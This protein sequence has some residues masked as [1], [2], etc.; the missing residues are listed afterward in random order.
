MNEIISDY[1]RMA[2]AEVGGKFHV[3]ALLRGRGIPVPDFFCLSRRLHDRWWQPARAEAAALLA[4]VDPRDRA[5]VTDAA[6]RLQALV[7]TLDIDAATCRAVH[8]ALDRHLGNAEYV[9]VRACMLGA[10]PEWSEDSV[11]DPHAGISATALYV[12]R[13]DVIARVRDGW[14]SAYSEQALLYRL[15]QGQDALGVSVAIGVQRM[16]FGERSFVMFTCD[17]NTT[18]RDTLLIAGHGIG[19]GVVQEAV[20]V[21]HYFVNAKS[22]AIERRLAVKHV[23]LGFDAERGQGLREFEVAPER[24]EAACL[25]DDEIRTLQALGRKIEQVFGWP[26]DIEGTLDAQGRVHILQARP[27]SID[28]VRKRLWTGLNI[29]E[30]YP[31]VSSPLTYSL[32]RLFYRVIFRDIYR[33]AGAPDRQL[34]EHHH[35]LDRMIG[36]VNGRIYYSLNAF[37]LLHGLVP[38][39]PWLCKAWENMVGLKTSYFIDAGEAAPVLPAWRRGW[40]QLRGWS[41]FAREFLML[42]RR[43][44]A[45]KQWWRERALQSRRVLQDERDALA[46][47]EEFHRLWRDVGR[48]WGV[49]LIND[50]Y[51]FT[52]HAIVQALFKRWRLDEDPALLSN[53]LCGDDQIES[54]EVF[55]SV[56]RIAAWVRSQPT[57]CA[58]FLASDDATL[59]QRFRARRL[60]ATLLTL[61]DDHIAAYGDR[62]MQEL[63]MENPSLRDDPTVLLR[64]VRRFVKAGLDPDASRAAELK[65]R[66]E[67]EAALDQRFGR[68]SLRKGLLRWMLKL[69]R[70]VIAHRE[71]S[72]YCRSE[73]FGICRDLFRAQAA[74]L[75]AQGAI[76]RADDIYYLTVDEITGYTDGTGVDEA[77]RET[78]ERRRRQLQAYAQ[79]EV[80]ET[81][82]TQGALRSNPLARAEA[83]PGVAGQAL[84]GLGSSMGVAQG[85]ARVVLDP[86]QVE[87]LPP[88]T[89]LVTR[90]TDP[91]W[92]F[93]MLASTGIVVER[94]SMLSHTAITGRKF[95]IPTVVGVDD[96]CRRIADGAPIEIDGGRGVVRFLDAA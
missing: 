92:L 79:Q 96:A 68:R 91:G 86:H 53:L 3:Q 76:E 16:V 40:Q 84:Q 77:F 93:L 89:I 65:Q 32:A 48:H 29:A 36:Y 88:D 20:P 81:L 46:L 37:Y 85:R 78:V 11:H 2:R 7:H 90:E 72:R 26:Q 52:L 34:T 23:G 44:R 95:G 10:R 64:G 50:A 47:T 22:G 17:P 31:G 63:K 80:P 57:L 38:I 75:V 30:S 56:L 9:S 87:D 5:S 59:V 43:M 66:A 6:R 18:A 25:D 62:S 70:E 49:T 8:D 82:A 13:E 14:A 27:V 45:Y 67:A 1:R 41:I 35:R 28:F 55:L 39:F 19:E 51:I 74:H 58:D 15:T 33:R 83:A 4:T 54:V 12:R 94:G 69:L 21:D 24:R 73:L 61:L 60:H 71:N 42:P